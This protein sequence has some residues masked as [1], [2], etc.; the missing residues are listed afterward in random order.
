MQPA[1]ELSEI[2][3][4][5]GSFY[6]AILRF[7]QITNNQKNL[8]AEELSACFF[9]HFPLPLPTLNHAVT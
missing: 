8:T 6:K 9:G 5:H 4:T 3:N 7:V 2:W 1:K